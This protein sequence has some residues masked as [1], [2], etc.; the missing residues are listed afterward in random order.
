[1]S[2]RRKL[3]ADLRAIDAVVVETR[4][5]IAPH[6]SYKIGGQ[7]SIW[8]E[9]QSERA[10]GQVLEVVHTHGERLF[11]LGGGSNVLVADEGWPGVVLY[12]SENLSGISFEGRRAQVL[13]GTPLLELIKKAVR[14][15]L[16]GMELMAGIPGSVG[17]ALRMN[18]GAFGQEIEATVKNVRGFLTDGTPV[19]KDRKQVSFGYRN[20]PELESVVITSASFEFKQ[21]DAKALRERVKDILS[22]RAEKQPLEHPSCGSVFKR[23]QG[24]YAGA[25]I[26][27]VGFKGR[28][29][30]RAMVSE[31]HAGFILNTG[32]ASAQEVK[33]L[34]EMVAGAVR[35]RFG[36]ELEREVKLIGFDGE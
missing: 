35:T 12:I 33:A 29:Y 1:M 27:E 19:A 10:A 22:I 23:P 14:R 4:H 8:V 16:G 5:R 26:E 20:A 28:V 2:S 34:M 36:V 18:A 13:A 24:Y 17:G 30:G 31:K 7:A 9:P 11:V 3:L 6:T 21:G 15:G 25:L 32:N